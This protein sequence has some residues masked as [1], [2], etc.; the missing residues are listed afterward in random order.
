MTFSQTIT[1]ATTF[2]VTHA[3][4]IAAKVATDL[5]RMQ[6]FY[7]KP[8]TERI[9]AYQN[10]AITLLAHGYL[11]SVAYG[12]QRNGCWVE[13]TLSYQAHDLLGASSTDDDP[14]K[15]RLGA[16]IGNAAFSSFLRYT[17]AWDRLSVAEQE[18]VYA[19]AGIPF[20]RTVGNEPGVDGYWSRDLTY[21]AGGRS[22]A[23]STV[24]SNR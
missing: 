10:E 7:K 14:G 8:S 5:M 23:R 3:K 19:N 24:R 12:F 22:L 15:I 13:P 16:N 18:A 20:R 4:H 21:S 9:D 6:R 17:A 2:T 1:Q 11:E